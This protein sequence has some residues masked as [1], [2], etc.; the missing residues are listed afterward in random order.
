M[1]GQ[2]QHSSHMIL[3]AASHGRQEMMETHAST[4]AQT[5]EHKAGLPQMN[6]NDFAPQLVWLALA[7]GVLYWVMSRIALPRIADA[8]ETR[9]RQIADDLDAA[10]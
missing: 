9:N 10:L 8:I 5:G 4:S 3:A 7:F 1:A 2:N 6:V